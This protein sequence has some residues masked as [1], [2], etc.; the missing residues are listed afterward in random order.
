MPERVESRVRRGTER[1]IQVAS[2]QPGAEAM[3]GPRHARFCQSAMD[4]RSPGGQVPP[5]RAASGELPG[6]SQTRG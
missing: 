4:T 5:D 2:C 1:A 6:G 3:G